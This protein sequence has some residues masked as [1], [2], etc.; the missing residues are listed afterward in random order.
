MSRASVS[1]PGVIDTPSAATWD[2]LVLPDHCIRSLQEF[3][4]WV[5]HRDKVELEWRGKVSGGPIALFSGP[6]GTGK[7]FAANVLGNTLGLNLYKVDLGLLV[8]KYIG[9]TEKNLS[10]L[11]DAMAYE[12]MLLVFDE[13]DSLFGKRR[14][15]EVAHDRYSN[16]E[17]KYL[18]SR[19]ERYKGPCVLTSNSKN[20][21]DSGVL[22]RFQFVI[23]FPL[24]EAAER[25]RLWRLYLPD[26]APIDRDV[27]TDSLARESELTGGQIRNAALHAAFLAAGESSPISSKHITSAV[28]AELAKTRSS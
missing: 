8:S 27:D 24:P 20:Q 6:S 17:L 5:T 25:S 26:R 12:P 21:I 4:L 19:L 18:L 7:T 16:A 10:A 15:V 28:E 1:L 22:R 3:A 2:D 23:E 9:E 11:F 13:A 14:E